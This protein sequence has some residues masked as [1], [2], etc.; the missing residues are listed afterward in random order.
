MCLVTVNAVSFSPEVL[1]QQIF[2]T[3]F[4][5]IRFYSSSD[6]IDNEVL[7]TPFYH[8]YLKLYHVIGS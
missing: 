2:W 1:L 3:N 5:D 8:R 7:S 6:T 4:V